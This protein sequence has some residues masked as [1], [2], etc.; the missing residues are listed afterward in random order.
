[1]IYLAKT[2]QQAL[3]S[4]HLRSQTEIATTTWAVVGI[5]RTGFRLEITS[6]VGN[7]CCFFSW[8][9]WFWT[10]TLLASH[11]FESVAT[12]WQA[13]LFSASRCFSSLRYLFLCRISERQRVSDRS[14]GDLCNRRW[15][16]LLHT[17]KDYPLMDR[18]NRLVLEESRTQMKKIFLLAGT[19]VCI[20]LR[21]PRQLFNAADLP[22]KT[23]E[24]SAIQ[25]SIRYSEQVLN[26]CT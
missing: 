7:S 10:L 12:Y 14:L 4:L 3:V 2:A 11:T 8:P 21:S 23:V 9:L 15:I 20:V 26:S 17:T 19:R 13:L 18:V 1:M 5:L 24:I 22:R 6:H 25:I 16:V